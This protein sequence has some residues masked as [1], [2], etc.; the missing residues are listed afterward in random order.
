[1]SSLPGE[2][3]KD[4]EKDIANENQLNKDDKK[5]ENVS[6]TFNFYTFTR[7]FL[8]TLGII[9]VILNSIYGFA[10]PN[11]NVDCFLDKSFELTE[12]INKYLAENKEARHILIACSS[13]CV[14]FVILYMGIYWC[15]Y[16]KSWRLITTLFCFY[17]IRGVIQ[18]YK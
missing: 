12:S 7:F 10:L 9:A 2:A 1:M 3:Y 17:G 15:M 13:F 11:S 6:F 14:D 5:E 4:I 18:V 8:F 16:G